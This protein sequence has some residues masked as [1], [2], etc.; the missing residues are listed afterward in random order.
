MMEAPIFSNKLLRFFGATWSTVLQSI[1]NVPGLINLKI[2]NLRLYV[3]INSAN[4]GII[5]RKKSYAG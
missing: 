4:P 3:T 5:L 2:I 1:A